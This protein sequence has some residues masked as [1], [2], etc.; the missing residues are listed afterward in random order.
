MSPTIALVVRNA[1]RLAHLSGCPEIGPFKQ[2]PGQTDV[3]PGQ[4]SKF[5]VM[6]SHRDLSY[7]GLSL[8]PWGPSCLVEGREQGLLQ[9]QLSPHWGLQC[10]MVHGKQRSCHL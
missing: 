5:W 2:D 7:S 8:C 3:F 4:C 1:P 10:T 6:N 9:S